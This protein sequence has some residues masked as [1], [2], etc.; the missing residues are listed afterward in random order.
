MEYFMYY[1]P[2]NYPVSMQHSSCKHVYSIRLEDNVD[3]YQM[4][5]SE[6]SLSGSKVFLKDESRFT[7]E[8]SP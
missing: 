6:A 5:F 8:H 7:F 2:H 4:F 1:T 3:P